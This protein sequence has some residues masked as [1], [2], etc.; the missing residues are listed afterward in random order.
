LCISKPSISL[1]KLFDGIPGFDDGQY[2]GALTLPNL[3]GSICKGGWPGLIGIDSENATEVIDRYLDDV[4]EI[5]ISRVDNTKRDPDRVKALLR[6]LARNVATTVKYATIAKDISEFSSSKVSDESA[7]EYMGLLK[8]LFLLRDI[9]A[10]EPALK[11]TVRLRR[12]PKRIFA[13]ASLAVSAL[14]AN[15]RALEEDPQTLWIAVREPGTA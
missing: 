1:A 11:S 8:R 4:A 6:S 3:T 10:W 15:A 9:P 13:D 2:V 14:G 12:T 5:D 7:S